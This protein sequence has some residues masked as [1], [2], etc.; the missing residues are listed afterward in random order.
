MGGGKVV[1]GQRRKHVVQGVVADRKRKEQPREEIGLH[2]VARVKN[3]VTEAELLAIR[4]E[5][6]VGKLSQLVEH[7]YADTKGI[8]HR[9]AC[10]RCKAR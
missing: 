2:K 6:V 4:I 8:Q 9:Y 10:P 7:E 3:V 1:V 5:L